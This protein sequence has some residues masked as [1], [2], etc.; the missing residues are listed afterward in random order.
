MA[1]MFWFEFGILFVAALFGGLTIM[2]YSLRLLKASTRSKPLKMSVS[3]LILISFLQTAVLSAIAIGIGLLTAHSIGLGAPYVEALAG[4][5]KIQRVGTMLPRAVALG[6]LGGLALV[7]M[8]IFFLPHLPLLL[9]LARNTSLQENFLASFYGGINEEFLTRLFGFS[10]ITWLLCKLWHTSTSTPTSP[11]FWSAN[12]IMAIIFGLGHLPAAKNLLGKITPLVLARTLLL[13]APFG[14]ICGWLF[15]HYG[16]E[17]AVVAHFSAD[18]VYHV[19]GTL[20][21]RLKD[22]YHFVS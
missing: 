15:W 12:I 7:L 3:M 10:I 19:G 4:A 20:V 16:I 8:D 2:P 6:S 17:A 11:V 1:T 18:I 22:R 13:N 21:L 14:L 9:E 5:E